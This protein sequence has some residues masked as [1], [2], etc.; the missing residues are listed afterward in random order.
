[1]LIMLLSWPDLPVPLI[2]A[3]LGGI[4]ALLGSAVFNWNQ[5]RIERKRLR[6]ILAIEMSQIALS[7]FVTRDEHFSDWGRDQI[8][9]DYLN[10]LFPHP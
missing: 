8:P 2:S 6:R 5:R 9:S 4:L 3:F 10:E 1:M 7:L